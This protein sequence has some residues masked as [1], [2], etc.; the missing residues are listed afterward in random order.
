MVW[1]KVDDKFHDHPKVRRL[2]KDA[3]AAV[4][5]WTTCGSW[6]A[7]NTTDG[8]IPKLIASRYDVRGRLASKLVDV[9]L[10]SR[11]DHGDEPGYQFHQWDEYQPTAASIEADRQEWRDK[12]AAQRKGKGKK[13]PG[14]TRGTPQGTPPKSPQGNLQG[15][16]AGFP[17]PVPVPFSGHPGEEG[18]PFLG[19]RENAPPP[20]KCQ[21][22]I[23]HNGD[24]GPCRACGDA[25]RANQAWHADQETRRLELAAAL[26]AARTDPRLRCEHGTDAGRYVRPDTGTSPC[27]LCRAEQAREPA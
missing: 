25:R 24:P 6:A 20:P 17:D 23:N 9:G 13:S 7:D 8:F 16:P 1:F 10:W 22:H 11:V 19:A 21:A 26:D 5:L 4:G 2:G 18:S 27:A 3:L 14:D 12:K 15:S